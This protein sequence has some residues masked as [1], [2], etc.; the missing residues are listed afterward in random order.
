[1]SNNVIFLLGPT[2]SGKTALACALSENF[3]LDIVSVDSALVYRDMNIGTAKPDAATLSRYPHQ[4]ID[5]ISPAETYSAA[6]FRRDALEAIAASHANGRTPILVG[7][8][9][10]YVKAL[11]EG[12]SELPIANP[13]IRGRIEAKAAESGWPALHLEL[14]KVDA[15]TAA[16]LSPNDGQ[17]IQRALEVYAATGISLS[18]QQNRHRDVSEHPN[19]FFFPFPYQAHVFGLLP[20]DRTALHQ[21]IEAR[22][23]AMIAAGLLE[24]LTEIRAKYEV[25]PDMPSMRAVGYRQAW[26]YLD[27]DISKSEFQVRA[28]IATRQLAKRQ[29]TWMRTMADMETFDCL[30]AAV[31]TKITTR[32]QAL[33]T[34]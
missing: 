13:I 3:P 7:G 15:L 5:L 9:M 33:L 19:P 28:V 4:L 6:Q 27:N 2:A 24:E 8:T 32:I 29:M 20:S 30:D 11:R 23:T 25:T 12:L 10:M 17:R 34:T 1:M 16:R 31:Q 22:F 21:R 18:A 26:Q 14:A